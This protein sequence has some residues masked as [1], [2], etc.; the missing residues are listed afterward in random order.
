MCKRI[1]DRRELMNYKNKRAKGNQDKKRT[2]E[3]GVYGK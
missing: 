2:S 1:S 3:L